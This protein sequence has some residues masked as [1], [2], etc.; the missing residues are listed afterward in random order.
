[1]PPV[2]VIVVIDGPDD[3][4]ARSL[5]TVVDPRVRVISLEQ[6]VGNASARNIGVAQAK[7]D[8]IAFLDDD[9]EWLARKLEVQLAVANSSPLHYP[10]VACRV[11]ARTGKA[12]LIWPWRFP[13][14]GEPLCDYLCRRSFPRS[15][16]GLVQT[17]MLFAPRDLF[18]RVR[19]IDGMRSFEDPDWLFRAVREPGAGYVFPPTCE[20][21]SIWHIDPGRSRVSTGTG[22]RES[23]EWGRKMRPLF[24]REAY[25]G[26]ICK[27]VSALAAASGEPGLFSMLLSETRRYGRPSW[28]DL[29]SHMMNF[30]ITP[31]TRDSIW[32]ILK[33]VRSLI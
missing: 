15:G 18:G 22:W 21:L 9:D 29:T 2:E 26:F 32:K 10:I 6:N 33:R 8:W 17:S 1:L 16:E 27:N 14:P 4:T 11:I 25:A 28:V 3:A 12:D 30:T 20:P 31:A 19:F 23:L 5:G 24:S 13:R 7:S